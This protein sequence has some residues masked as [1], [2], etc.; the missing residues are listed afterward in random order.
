LKHSILVLLRQVG[1]KRADYY[2][3][4]Q[5]CHLFFN[6]LHDFFDFLLAWQEDQHVPF[7]LKHRDLHSA[8]DS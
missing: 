8:P 4:L 5:E 7:Y 2:I 6:L 3:N 1:E